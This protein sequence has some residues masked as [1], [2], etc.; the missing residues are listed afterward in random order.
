MNVYRGVV[1]NVE[2]PP[3]RSTDVVIEAAAAVSLK[4]MV[5]MRRVAALVMVGMAWRRVDR[6][7]HTRV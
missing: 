3:I 4:M 7:V 2:K 6:K 1:S 5:V